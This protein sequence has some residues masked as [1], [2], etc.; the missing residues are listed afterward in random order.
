[1]CRAKSIV[2]SYR[3]KFG[4]W[5]RRI[6]TL[7]ARVSGNVVASSCTGGTAIDNFE[8]NRGRK[9]K[10]KA[11]YSNGKVQKNEIL[12]SFYSNKVG[13]YSKRLTW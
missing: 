8:A 11:P 1:M 12:G 9:V 7:E 13:N 6:A 3:K 10:A 4:K 5:H 2:K